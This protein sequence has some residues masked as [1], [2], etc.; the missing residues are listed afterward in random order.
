MKIL[1]DGGTFWND[2]T[3][4]KLYTATARVPNGDCEAAETARLEFVREY[5]QPRAIATSSLLF[6]RN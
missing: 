6:L 5:T 4:E 2:E 3:G 1:Q